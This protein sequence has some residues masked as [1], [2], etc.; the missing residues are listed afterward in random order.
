MI[1]DGA[2][3]TVCALMLAENGH[4]VRL[5]SAFPDAARDLAEH[6]ENRR[7]LPEIGRAHV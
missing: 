1:G 6:R 7:F 3:G 4:Q 5:W 2:M